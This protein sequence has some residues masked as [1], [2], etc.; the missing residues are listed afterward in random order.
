MAKYFVLG[1][2]GFLGS[3][4]VSQLAKREENEIIVGDL[5]ANE[6]IAKYG[7]VSF[8]KIDFI[9]KEDF[10]EELKGIDVVYHLISTITPSDD[11]QHIWDELEAN[12]RPTI[13]LLDSIVKFKGIK[14]VFISSGGTVYGNVPPK[15]IPEEN[16]LNPVCNYGISK[17]LIEK[18]IFL[19]HHM[20]G[21]DYRII[22]LA[23]PYGTKVKK[24]QKQGLIP[25][26][27][28]KIMKN[29]PVVVFGTG[30]KV[31]DYIHIDD[32]IAAV[33]AVEK[34]EGERKVFNVGVGE[35][36]SILQILDMIVRELDCPYPQIEFI[37]D[38]K[39]DVE[40]NVLDNRCIIEETGWSPSISLKQG[41]HMMIENMNEEA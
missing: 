11:T 24:N 29:E 17:E 16:A 4:I 31:R 37:P 10:T 21:L 22:R 7:N 9:N 34:Y 18:Y 5:A 26:F 27:I 40:Y 15:P 12:V 23:N 19:Y 6:K 1:G 8:L 35:G 13:R 30:E 25:I 36:H 39:C 2:S 32:A 3:K 20:Y 14:L 33:F 41:I 38:R 28:D